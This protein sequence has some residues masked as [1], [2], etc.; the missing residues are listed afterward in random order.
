MKKLTGISLI[1]IVFSILI[2]SNTSELKAQ[3]RVNNNRFTI[4]WQDPAEFRISEHEKYDI[5][6]FKD[7]SY[8][9]V[10]DIPAF[11]HRVKSLYSSDDLEVRLINTITE[12][13]SDIE[14]Q[15][16]IKNGFDHSDF[17]IQKSDGT[18]KK[19]LYTDIF[20]QPIRKTSSNSYEKLISFEIQ[21]TVKSGAKL[22][23]VL[24]ARKTKI[25]SVLENG[26][27]YKMRILNDGIHKVTYD[28]LSAI[29]MAGDATSLSVFSAGGVRLPEAAGDPRVD[30]LK[31]IPIEI[32]DGGDGS[33]DQGDY[34]LFYAVGAGE[35]RYDSTKQR[36]IYAK[37]LYDY[38]NYY[39]I[40][41]DVVNNGLRMTVKT[42]PTDNTTHTVTS[43]IDY[44]R[45][46][47]DSQNLIKSGRYWY[48]EEFDVKTSY[49]INFDFPNMVSGTKAYIE[50]SLAA[51]SVIASTFTISS[52]A[53]SSFI[54][55]GSTSTA[56]NSIY[57]NRGLKGL[58]PTVSGNQ[59]PVTVSYNKPTSSSVGWLNYI[60]VNLLRELIFTGSQMKFRDTSNINTGNVA[61][62]EIRQA[63]SNLRVWDITDPLNPIGIQGSMNS[64]TFEFKQQAHQLFQYIAFNGS[65]YNS[66]S[67]FIKV[68]KQNL[69]GIS[70]VDYIIITHPDFRDQAE[71]LAELHRQ[72]NKL[73]VVLVEPEQ[74]YNEFSSGKQDP[75]AIRD[76][77]KYL[78]DNASLGEEPKYLLLFGDGSYD[79]LDRI[80]ENTNFIVS[81]QS[82]ES[83]HPAY[84]YVTDDYFGILDNNEGYNGY[85]HLD[86][87]VGRFPVSNI[88][89]ATQMVDKVERYMMKNNEIIASDNCSVNTG[90]KPFGDWRNQIYLIADDEDSN[91]HVDQ[92]ENLSNS[93]GGHKDYNLGKIYLDAFQQESTSG[94]QRY[95]DVNLAINQAMVKGSLLINYIGHGGE[96]GWAHERIIGVDDIKSWKNT[97][98]MPLFVTATCEFSR[99]D[100]PERTSAGEYTFLNSEGGAIALYTT[101]RLAFASSNY[102]YNTTLYNFFFAMEDDEHLS[103]GEI[104]QKTKVAAG[105]ESTNR[106]IIL[107]GDPALTL[108]FPKY[109]IEATKVNGVDVTDPLDTLKAFSKIT[110]SGVV[111]DLDGQIKSDFN[112]ILYPTVYDKDVKAKTL[113]NDVNSIPKN[114]FMQKSILYKGKASIVNGEWSFTFIVPKDIAYAYGNGKFS[115]YAENGETDAQGHFIDIIVGGTSD[116]VLDDDLGPEISLYMNDSNFVFGGTTDENP[117]IF[118]L[119]KD[120]NGINTV[121]NGI[122]HD[123][124]AV[125]DE[126]TDQAIIL[127][128]YYEAELDSY[129]KGSVKYALSNIPE[130]VHTLSLK[131]WDINNNSSIAV[132][133]FVVE[134]A[135]EPVLSHV[136][137]YPNP[138]TT[139]TEFWFEH[140]QACC[141]LDV[142]VQVFTVSGKLV[143]SIQTTVQTSGYKADPIP[144]DGRDDYGDKLARG[145]YIYK[146]TI[147]NKDNQT[148]EQL[149]KLVILK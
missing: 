119:L 148:A 19:E 132:T 35:W 143:K 108:A 128:D 116:D 86:I 22:A 121:G 26:N 83:L 30:D 56:Y 127:N 110:V 130:G 91:L 144:W 44:Q 9:I 118:A 85:G 11:H 7:C 1:I 66:V 100:D 27:W 76:F 72:V 13:V 73:D 8:P 20:I 104:F 84:T 70:D 137:N 149:E 39:Y 138:F 77:I 47:T 107:L 131:A 51:R 6:R 69:H 37:H 52:L 105:S 50:T 17:L 71:R 92:A 99:F 59:L 43:F 46:E 134:S 147:K 24:P 123:I 93:I 60:H 5:I 34:I 79:P 75:T 122:G 97:Y 89:Q 140:N 113:G 16:L 135:N 14:K 117:V 87:A 64:G 67:K 12:Q 78:Y 40:S 10:F 55:I 48:G 90:G 15:I 2:A 101:T 80:E 81:F 95:P 129:N 65:A 41:K 106:N 4:E 98:S 103:I 114:F 82:R 53:S 3:E 126:N 33:I 36:F 29:G 25:N 54:S 112:G 31:E 133:E 28:E 94:G 124:V 96:L 125:L 115:F 145:V 109:K 23:Q 58:T 62:F 61:K 63:P 18:I 141:D 102:K 45:H 88:T 49:L 74:I 38:Y 142:L 120:E 139:Y 111:K 32:V 21:V 57:A 42:V 68:E 146:I 136:L